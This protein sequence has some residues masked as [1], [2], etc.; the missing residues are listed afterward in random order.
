MLHV[1]RPLFQW[2]AYRHADGHLHIRPYNQLDDMLQA[3]ARRGT[4]AVFGP[5]K[6]HC[7]RDARWMIL[8]IEKAN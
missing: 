7:P 4:V 1:K 5:V 3:A 2:W 8:A 6:A